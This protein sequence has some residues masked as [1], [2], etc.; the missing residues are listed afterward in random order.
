MPPMSLLLWP[1]MVAV[2]CSLASNL[3]TV[4]RWVGQVLVIFKK[5]ILSA[6]FYTGFVDIIP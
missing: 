3:V 2:N 4:I 5:E 6:C 1:E